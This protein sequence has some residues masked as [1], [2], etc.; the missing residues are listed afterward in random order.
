MYDIK[1]IHYCWILELAKL[2]TYEFFYDFVKPAFKDGSVSFLAG[3]TD[4]FILKIDGIDS[5]DQILKENSHLFDFSNLSKGHPLKDDSNKIVPGKVKLEFCALSP[6]CYSMK[7]DTGYKQAHKGSKKDLK[8]ELYKQC[9]LSDSC[10]AD[11]VSEIRNYG[12]NLYHVSATR[13]LLT[14]IDTK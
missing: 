10:H 4:S 6:K 14:P 12:Q 9:M 8:H 11:D 5:V 2:V 3:D 13:R 7:T 1:Q